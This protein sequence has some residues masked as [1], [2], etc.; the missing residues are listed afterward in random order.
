MKLTFLGTSHGV[1][2][3]DRFCSCTLLETGGHAY[4]IDCGAPAADLLIRHGVPF[5]SLR[6][7]FTT[8]MHG[9]HTMGLPPL[10][11][12][13]QWYCKEADFDVFLAEEAGAA[14]LKAYI[15]SCDPTPEENRIR[16]HA[17]G[18][19]L[20]FADDRITVTAIP[21]AHCRPRPS[22]AL[23]IEAEGKRIIFTGDMHGND[24]ADFPKIAKEEPS[25]LIVCEA[26]HFSIET[27]LGI[28]A[29]C[30][31]KNL[32]FHHVFRDYDHAVEVLRA[33][34]G[35]YPTPIHHAADGD[36]LEL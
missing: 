5:T 32:W 17:F 8:H 3:T 24:A 30:P 29:A 19:G 22:Y 35:Q 28:A 14:A 1:P 31:T 12:L 34:D 18:E 26:A 9:D 21:T 27:I 20:F 25:D 2:M 4:L 16:Y 10:C 33:A 7:V 36:V 6:A 23:M 11:S 15:H 13:S